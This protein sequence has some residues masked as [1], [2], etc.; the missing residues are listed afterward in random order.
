MKQKAIFRII[1]G[2]LLAALVLLTDQAVVYVQGSIDDYEASQPEHVVNAVLE[3]FE[4]AVKSG[5]CTDVITYPDIE[6]SPYEGD[7]DS[8]FA[9]YNGK[10]TNVSE[11]TWKILSG[12]YSETGQVYGF[13]GDGELLAKLLLKCNDSRII[14]EILTANSWEKDKILPV[15]TLTKYKEYIDIPAGFTAKLNGRTV[16]RTSKGV[17]ITEKN[18]RVIYG[19]DNLYELKEVQVY[20]SFGRECPCVTENGYCTAKTYGYNLILPEFYSLY[21]GEHKLTGVSEA[22]GIHYEGV[23]SED[24]LIIGDVYGNKVEYRSGDVIEAMDVAFVLPDNFKVEWNGNDFEK[25]VTE[26]KPIQKYAD[27]TDFAKMPVLLRYEMKGLLKLPELEITDNFG[28]RAE[29]EFKGNYFEI[30]EQAT[31]A[32]VP[33][34]VIAQADPMSS[35][36]MWSL[37]LS[38]D[39]GGSRHGFTSL[40]KYLVPGTDFYE[41]AEKFADS[42]DITFVSN[43]SSTK[44]VEERV[45]NYIRYAENLF[46]CDIYLNKEMYLTTSYEK[47]N[48]Y[49]LIDSTFFFC[50]Y[51]G[52]WRIAGQRARLEN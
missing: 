22:G 47:G 12:S 5:R 45:S 17:E 11:W 34:N 10:I 30:T 2:I 36:K 21:D 7:P 41:Y 44:F 37:F 43:H 26:R 14:M 46:S 50:L 19:I 28:Q 6:I 29:Y 27:Y 9:E 15:I 25:Y 42:I 32:E 40:R 39:I 18:G 16:D 33:E 8:V 23:S 48:C 49:D 1:Y 51:D 52:K 3:E 20:D 38:D 13:Y 35:V 24:H 4:T 31:L